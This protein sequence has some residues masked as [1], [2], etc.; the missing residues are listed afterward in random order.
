[1]L[2][3]AKVVAIGVTHQTVVC[4]CSFSLT[5]AVRSSQ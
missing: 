5:N 3:S 2:C 4:E 1:V